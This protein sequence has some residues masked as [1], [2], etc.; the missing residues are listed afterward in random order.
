NTESLFSGGPGESVV[1]E[2]NRT[3]VNKK[4]LMPGGK[5]RSIVKL[6]LRFAGQA[7][8]S[9][10]AMATGWL[11]NGDTIVTAGH[12]AYDW[13]HNLGRLTHVKAYIGY[14]GKESI[15]DNR[16]SAVQFR[17]AKRVAVLEDWLTNGDNEPRDVAFIQVDP[18]FNGIKPIKHQPTPLTGTNVVLGVVG[19]PGDLMNPKSKERGAFMYEMYL[20][21]N[22]DVSKTKNKM[23]QYTIDTYGGNSGSPVIRKPDMASIGVHVLGG[24]PNSASVISGPYGNSFDALG[25]ALNVKQKGSQGDSEATVDGNEAD[26]LSWITIPIKEQFSGGEAD[27]PAEQDTGCHDKETDHSETTT[28]TGQPD[29]ESGSDEE[30]FNFIRKALRVAGP[31]GMIASA[32]L[33]VA[34]KLLARKKE[35][36]ID[37]A[38][39]FDGVA[40]RALLGEAALAAVVQ[41]GPSK[42]KNLG[43]FKRMQPTIRNLQPIYRRAGPAIIPFVMERAWRMTAAPTMLTAEKSAEEPI[44]L[45]RP[46]HSADTNTVVFGPRLDVNSEAFVEK[47]TESLSAEGTE[48]FADTESGIGTIIGRAIRVAGPVLGGPAL[49]G[50]VRVVGRLVEADLDQD[51][52]AEFNNPESSAY[53]YNAMTQR[54]IAGEAAL[55]ALLQTP[56]EVLEQEGFWNKIN[57][58][59]IKY[60]PKFL[61]FGVG[62]LTEADI[63]AVAASLETVRKVAETQA[64]D[65]LDSDTAGKPGNGEPVEDDTMTEVGEADFLAELQNGF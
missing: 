52:E 29:S 17:T 19:Y 44:E 39:S 53:T 8:S 28:P 7:D 55:G 1:G 27:M 26:W 38:Y 41:L 36:A 32:G 35:S 31:M 43:I 60:G 24:N 4:D 45:P 9:P 50:I 48:A 37:E 56:V 40:E 64:G 34:G 10:W 15:K 65:R 61:K 63:A 6:F 2:D 13:S 49:A 11:I 14:Y 59:L 16:N 22:F 54:A 23:L 12:C 62:L 20:G 46:V 21:T 25:A 3:K 30:F 51:T 47:L 18:P 58:P 33:S 42:C 5:Y 57:G